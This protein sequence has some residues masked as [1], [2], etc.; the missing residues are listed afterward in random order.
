VKGLQRGYLVTAVGLQTLGT[1]CACHSPHATL[2]SP[3][4]Y[5]SMV[6][7]SLTCK[8]SNLLHEQPRDCSMAWPGWVA[9]QK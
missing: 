5:N 6:C 1:C 4:C 8:A 7:P 3:H 2:V 9:T